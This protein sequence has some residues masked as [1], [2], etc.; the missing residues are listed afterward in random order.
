VLHGELPSLVPCPGG[1]GVAAPLEPPGR[2]PVRRRSQPVVLGL[3]AVWD[4][5]TTGASDRCRTEATRE[6]SCGL[7]LVLK[8]RSKRHRVPL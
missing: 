7:L 2:L 5:R 8:Q 1:G 6:G 3:Q 4:P